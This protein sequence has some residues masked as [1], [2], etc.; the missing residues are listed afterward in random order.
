M[1]VDFL[2]QLIAANQGG[3]GGPSFVGAAVLGA[4]AIPETVSIDL[5][6]SVPGIQSGD[7]IVACFMSDSERSPNLTYTTGSGFVGEPADIFPPRTSDAALAAKIWSYSSSTPQFGFTTRDGP[8]TL[9]VV[10]IFCVY[11]GVSAIG[12]R[13]SVEATGSSGM[14]DPGSLSGISASSIVLAI[15]GLDD[16]GVSVT[17]QAGFSLATSAIVSTG[18]P[19]TVMLSHQLLPA[20][21]TINPGAFIGSGDD[22]WAAYTVELLAP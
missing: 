11:R 2:F 7:V 20:A 17:P 18:S 15:G 4:E 13:T 12:P 14:P 21:G 8:S 9:S 10:W 16:D 22:T 6:S 19:A 3:G 1:D 5:S